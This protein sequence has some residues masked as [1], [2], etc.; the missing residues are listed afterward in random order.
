MPPP[1]LVTVS[2]MVG[3][4]KST[5]ES[6]ILRLLRRKDV[7]AESW[8]FRTLPCFA[9]PF[10]SSQG[11]DAPSRRPPR[12]VRGRGYKRRP[13][14]FGATVGYLGRMVAFRVYRRWRQPA[15]WTVCN[16][17]FYD[18]L[19]HFDLDAHEARKYLVALRWF[20]PQP[21]LAILFA[22]S[23][24]VIAERRP[25]YAGEYLEQVGQA[26]SRLT[27]TFPNLVVVNSD[28]AQ[29][30]EATLDRLIDDFL[31]RR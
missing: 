15:G 6:R 16:R 31:R 27:A 5:G 17:Y 30:G 14:T 20:M 19:A 13:L 4:G 9:F 22:A 24:A 7:R 18:S 10:G 11:P 12:T 26:Y 29:H 1:I 28:P 23:P 21:D 2:G 8:R 25:L 3:A